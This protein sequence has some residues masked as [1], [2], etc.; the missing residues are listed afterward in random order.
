MEKAIATVAKF[1]L[2]EFNDGFTR[3]QFRA[4]I[5]PFLRQVKGRRGIVD[6][7]VICDETNNPQS[8]VGCK[9]IPSSIFVKPNRNINFITLN[10]V[11]R[12]VWCRI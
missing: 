9:S 10:F 6:F 8:V 1:Q 12:W 7:Q 5:E 11:A 2:F 4:T 3:G